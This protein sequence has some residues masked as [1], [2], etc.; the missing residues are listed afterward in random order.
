MSDG[1]KTTIAALYEYGQWANERLLEKLRGLGHDDLTR[2]LLEGRPAHPADARASLR[3]R[4]SGGS[5][6]GG[7]SPRPR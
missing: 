1:M 7:S 2:R 5:P 3:G 6:A 4:P